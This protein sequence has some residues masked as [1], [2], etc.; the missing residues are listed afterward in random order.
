MFET[1]N[2]VEA[3]LWMIMGLGFVIAGSRYA[4]R[5]R[6]R[7]FLVGVTLIVFGASDVVET[8]TGAWWRPWWL[9][10]WKGFCLVALGAFAVAYFRRRR[11][12]GRS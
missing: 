9:L 10:A 4:A 2:Y 7:F 6:R 11:S 5:R 1:A 3:A 12:T 8:Q